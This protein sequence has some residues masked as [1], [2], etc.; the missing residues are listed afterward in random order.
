M[1]LYTVYGK[2]MVYYGLPVSKHHGILP[3]FPCFKTPRYFTMVSLFQNN[4]VFYHGFPV[5]KQHGIYHEIQRYILY[6]SLL[7]ITIMWAELTSFN[8]D[9]HSWE[10]H[11]VTLRR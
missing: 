2:C 7:V 8:G 4:T 5:L 9:A 1:F 10:T 3:W 11:C 6:R